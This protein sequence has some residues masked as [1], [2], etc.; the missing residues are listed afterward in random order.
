[1]PLFAPL[2]VPVTSPLARE[3]A[4]RRTFAIISHP[5]A[6]KTTLTEKLLLL[7]GAIRTAGDVRARKTNRHARS[8]W[9]AIEKDRGISVTSSVMKFAYRGL[10]MNLLDTPGHEDF[11]E[12]T[13]RVLTAVDSV[14]MVIDSVKGVEEQ[15]RKL[16]DVCRLRD[17]PIITFINKLDREGRDGLDLLSD[18]EESLDI[19][20]VPVTWPVSRGKTLVGTYNLHQRSLAVFDPDFQD[21]T[22]RRVEL[23]D[24][25]TEEGARLLGSH[26]DDLAFDIELFDSAGT[27]FD[28]D[29]YLAGKQTPVIFGSAVN[30]FG[31]RDLLDLFV[32]IAP[33]PRPRATLTRI[34]EPSEK[35]FSGVVFKIQ[36]NMDPNH[37][38]R[39][40]F[41]RICSGKFERGVKAQH[42]RLGREVRLNNA[43]IFLAQD[44]DGVEEAYA[45]DI[46]GIPNHGIFRI[47][48]T[49]SVGESLRFTGI[50]S[51]A[52]E[53]FR[54]ARI[55]N[56]LRAKQ[57]E[58]GLRHLSEEGA[59]QFYRPL[60]TSDYVLGAVGP[61]QFDV[62]AA[63]LEAEYNVTIRLESLP[64][65]A[66]RWV[67]SDDASEL[68][69][70]R[71]QEIARLAHDA[72]GNLVYLAESEFWI[73]RA[74]EKWDKIR[75]EA[76]KEHAETV[77]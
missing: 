28:T 54:R 70:L 32:A 62:V 31:V 23:P 34:V 11:S 21:A 33:S 57:L 63:R 56:A 52:A 17:T 37:R 3:V 75:F 25:T 61:L 40:A 20:A 15:T 30:G 41:L 51:F 45:G 64:Y 14:L 9:M 50:P 72:D 69:R 2:Q 38:D 22:A 8:D 36:A 47:G 49:I 18:I 43:T 58:K 42:P 7:G 13:Y 12:D 35:D 48:D 1:L 59:I 71:K 39:M 55:D 29:R 19:E 77:S 65:G 16:M 74:R 6:G 66:V 67:E 68:D 26:Q 44:R 10:E 76:T 4:R 73:E 46:I 60:L 53:H 27:G 5:D 24:V